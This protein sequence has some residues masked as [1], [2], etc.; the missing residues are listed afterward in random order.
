MNSQLDTM[1]GYTF[2]AGPHAVLIIQESIKL[3]IFK[4]FKDLFDIEK[5]EI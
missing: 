2:D 3:L 4:L 5:S 1:T